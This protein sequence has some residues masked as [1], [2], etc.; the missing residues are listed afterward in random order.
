MIAIRGA[1]TIMKNTEEEIKDA[2]LE[3]IN[4]IIDKNSLKKEKILS[5]FF[6]CTKD[7]N[8]EYP[9]KFVREDL[10]LDNIAIMHFN[11]MEVEKE[12]YLKL[13]I[14]VTLFYNEDKDEIYHIYLKEAKKL[15]KDLKYNFN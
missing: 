14:R 11:E 12:S 9:G 6:S 15:R 1:T 5:I 10:S 4:T 2:S 7:V 13:C 3:L 8:V